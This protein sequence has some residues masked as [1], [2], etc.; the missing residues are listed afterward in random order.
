MTNDIDLTPAPVDVLDRLDGD[1][2]RAGLV[3]YMNEAEVEALQA[4]HLRWML[5]GFDDLGLAKITVISS[6]GAEV[7]TVLVHWSVIVRPAV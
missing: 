7:S 4:G 1:L 3:S 2:I 5:E 6:G